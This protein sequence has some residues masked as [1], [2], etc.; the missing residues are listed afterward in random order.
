VH[1]G[2]IQDIAGAFREAIYPFNFKKENIVTDFSCQIHTC[3][4][5]H[6]IVEG[7]LLDYIRGGGVRPRIA[8]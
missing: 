5:E 2:L 8:Y 1:G 6:T 4:D 3:R 7:A